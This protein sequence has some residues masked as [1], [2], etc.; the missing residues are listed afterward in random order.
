QL[1]KILAKHHGFQCTVLFA[2]DPKDGTINPTRTNN[3]PGLEALQK[4]DL[5][6]LFTR[7]RDLPDEQM[8]Y[9]VDYVES[10]RPI[11]G[12]RT[13]TH[14]FKFDRKSSKT[15]AAYGFDS[16]EWDG[17]FGRQ[18]L[19]ETWLS[20]HGQHGKQ[21]TCGILA[22]GAEGH[23]ILRGIQDGDIWGPT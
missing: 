15:Y 1:G 17:G 23:P 20:H 11:I 5:L 12:M 18:V 14:A 9:V 4:A 3:I 6:V 22:P 19:G 7:F 8:K 2:I 13:A 10:G 16:K 21:S